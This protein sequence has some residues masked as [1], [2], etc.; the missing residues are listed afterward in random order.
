MPAA[1]A[2]A[3]QAPAARRRDKDSTNA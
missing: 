3:L 2:S 1:R